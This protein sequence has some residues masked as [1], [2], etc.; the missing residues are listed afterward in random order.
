M[1][2]ARDHGLTPGLAGKRVVVQG[3][4]NVGYR[5]A[6]FLQEGG[7][8]LVGLAESEGAIADPDGLDLESVEGHRKET[9][10]IT[11][12][13]GARDLRQTLRP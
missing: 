7:A 2:L 3:L 6:K 4:G 13:P 8:V 12:F 9:N 5:A 11:G 1:D 10:R